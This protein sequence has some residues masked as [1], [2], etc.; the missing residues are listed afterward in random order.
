MSIVQDGCIGSASTDRDV[1]TLT[2][3][4]LAVNFIKKFGLHF[5]LIVV[6]LHISHDLYVS[7][8]R[9]NCTILHHVDFIGALDHTSS[10]QCLVQG[11]R[12]CTKIGI[13]RCNK[14]FLDKGVESIKVRLRWVLARIAVLARQNVN[15]AF[16]I[17]N[18]ASQ[19]IAEIFCIKDLIDGIQRL[20]M[21]RGINFTAPNSI[22]IVQSR[23][24]KDSMTILHTNRA[25]ELGFFDAEKIVEPRV[26]SKI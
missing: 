4:T 18:L 3:T 22:R 5:V 15:E 8:A 25:I 10:T 21:R 19:P 2:A 6:V 13:T 26:L 24:E 14:S 9:N 7:I 1:S 17:T 20:E 16:V 12:I 11:T 23:H